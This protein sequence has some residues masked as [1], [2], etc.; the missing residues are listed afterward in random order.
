MNKKEESGFI[1]K[2]KKR[3]KRVAGV[4]RLELEIDFCRNKKGIRLGKVWKRES[5]KRI[6]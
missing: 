2:K 4:M 6:G 1:R 3:Y 5:V